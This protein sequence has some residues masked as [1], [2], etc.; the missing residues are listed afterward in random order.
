MD[1]REAFEARRERAMALIDTWS[2]RQQAVY[3]WLTNKGWQTAPTLVRD[4]AQ[5]PEFRDLKRSSLRSTVHRIIDRLVQ[6]G[7]II[8]RYDPRYGNVGR[9][10]NPVA[11]V[12]SPVTSLSAHPTNP[13]KH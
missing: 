12:A 8:E 13:H 1:D 9:P 3:R 4:M 10:G 7:V 11:T 2:P 5:R 6:A